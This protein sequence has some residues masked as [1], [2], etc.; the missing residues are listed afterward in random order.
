MDPCEA[1]ATSIWLNQD[2]FA[3][4]VDPEE[5]GA[6]IPPVGS[7]YILRPGDVREYS[8]PTKYALT[9]RPKLLADGTQWGTTA[10]TATGRNAYA[11]PEPGDD[12]RR[13]YNGRGGSETS[14]G[15]TRTNATTRVRDW[16]Q[17]CNEGYT[18][19]PDPGFVRERRRPLA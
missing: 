8:F 5:A 15:A 2:P 18:Y 11:P 1:V 9:V 19:D 16:V 12:T 6:L 14:W 13:E 7:D 10:G 3:L 17:T 4:R